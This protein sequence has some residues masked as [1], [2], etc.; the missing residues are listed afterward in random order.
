MK[1][2]KIL[3][4]FFTLLI[5]L[6]L[7][8]QKIIV[9]GQESN[10]KLTWDDFTG[11]ADKSTP[12]KA[13]TSFRYK[14][15]IEGISF[16]GD[17]AIINGYEVILELDPKK[18]WAIKDEVSDELLVHEQGHFNIGILCIREIMVKF[19]Q[20]KFTTS[21]FSQLLSNLFKSTTNKYSELTLNYDKET[22]HS[23]NKVQQEKWNKFFTEELK[24]TN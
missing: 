14:T 8:S 12:F 17:T 2:S 21:N 24:G 9:N 15:K 10:G 4:L 23:K 6:N 18:S 19:K 22:D 13:F 1:S 7:F 20:T 3:I 11:K 16:V 5:S